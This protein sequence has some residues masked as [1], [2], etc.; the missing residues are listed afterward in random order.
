[1][2]KNNTS[3]LSVHRIF[4]AFAGSPA[5]PAGRIQPMTPALIST[6]ALPSVLPLTVPAFGRVWQLTPVFAPLW[7]AD[8]R[9]TALEMLS[10]LQDRDSGAPAAPEMFF[11]QAPQAEQLR[12]LHWQLDVLTLL[13]PWCRR[14]GVAVSLNITRGLALRLL[15]EPDMA[16]V[17]QALSPSLRLEVSERFLSPDTSPDHD[18][19]L[20][21]LRPL[22]P[23]WLD[24]FGAGATGLSWMMSGAFEAVKVDRLF[25]RDLA[26]LPEGVYFLQALTALAGAVDTRMV[27]E[28]VEDRA[29]MQTALSAGVDTCQGWLWPEVTLAALAT[30]PAGLPDAEGD[31]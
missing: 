15:G 16:G 27:A 30:L 28:G 9:L 4:T 29:L 1:M 5:L 20:Q 24:D 23:L 13:M 8:G 25:F 22:A 12:I 31:L 21:G 7:G 26:A 18:P 10:R 17:V 3:G 2:N 14:R 19:L 6:P 11:A